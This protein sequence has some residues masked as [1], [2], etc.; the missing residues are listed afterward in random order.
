MATLALLLFVISL[1]N[2]EGHLTARVKSQKHNVKRSNLV[3]GQIEVNLG[4]KCSQSLFGRSLILGIH[5]FG[6]TTICTH[7][8]SQIRVLFPP[9]N[10]LS[11]F[12]FLIMNW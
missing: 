1:R 12:T 11:I 6:Y 9:L 3:G 10:S 4:M 8:M 2:S 7:K 5:F